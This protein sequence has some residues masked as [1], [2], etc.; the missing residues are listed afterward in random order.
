M[1]V[2][3]DAGAKGKDEEQCRKDRRQQGKAVIL[4]TTRV[5]PGM[6]YGIMSI[7]AVF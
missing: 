6:L 1:S 2:G 3:A 4:V 7:L 5:A